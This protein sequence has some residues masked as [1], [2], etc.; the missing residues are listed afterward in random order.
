MGLWK[1]KQEDKQEK[2]IPVEVYDPDEVVIKLPPGYQPFIVNEREVLTL[3]KFLREEWFTVEQ[4]ENLT[5]LLQDLEKFAVDMFIDAC[6]CCGGF[7][8]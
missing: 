6:K 8:E 2:L 3:I 4:D 5:K 7:H 1:R